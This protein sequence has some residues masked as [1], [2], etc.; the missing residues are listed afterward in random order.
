LN[1]KLAREEVW[2]RKGI[3]AR[4]TRNEGRVSALMKLREEQQAWRRQTGTSRIR[5]QEAERTGK[6]VIEAEDITHG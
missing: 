4:R 5:I 1:K 2:I 3:K 6:L